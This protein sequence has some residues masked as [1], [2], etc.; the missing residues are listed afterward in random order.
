[1]KLHRFD[2][3]CKEGQDQNAWVPD[4]NGHRACTYLAAHRI[5]QR[6]V[7]R[8]LDAFDL[9]PRIEPVEEPLEEGENLPW[10]FTAPGQHLDGLAP[11]HVAIIKLDGTCTVIDAGQLRRD[12]RGLEFDVATGQAGTSPMTIVHQIPWSQ[13]SWL[14]RYWWPGDPR[15]VQELVQTSEFGLFEGRTWLGVAA[16]P[17]VERVPSSQRDEAV[18]LQGEMQTTAGLLFHPPGY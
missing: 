1:M 17:G 4:Q 6:H 9:F 10:V 8:A 16:Y 12:P 13:V 11:N 3:V 18:R 14:F 2:E 7:Q 5:I 15:V